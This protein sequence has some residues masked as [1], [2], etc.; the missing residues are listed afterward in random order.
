MGYTSSFLPAQLVLPC[1][2]AGFD[3]GTC[4]D[5]DAALTTAFG[6]VERVGEALAFSFTDYYAAEM[7]SNLTRVFFVARDLVAPDS[8]ARAKVQTNA[9]EERF[10]RDGGRSV[11]IDPGLL[12]PG[13]FILA[14]TKDAAHRIPLA[15][16]IYGEITLLFGKG[17]FR[18]LPWTYP[19]FR[20]DEY[21]AILRTIRA[22]YVTELRRRE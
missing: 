18:P 2:I 10:T 17:D 7:G 3:R 13:R 9:V 8:L 11:N 16:G 14:T 4:A 5:V 15:E 21:R 22:R 1:L 19:D 20:S 6:P 12:L